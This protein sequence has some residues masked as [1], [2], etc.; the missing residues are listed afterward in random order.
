VVQ[1][2]AT[3]PPQVVP[4]QLSAEVQASPSLQVLPAQSES[5]Q[6]VFPS[7]S[8]SDRSLHVASV[9]TDPHPHTPAVQNSPL[10]PQLVPLVRLGW[11]HAPAPSQRSEVQ[12][13]LSSG[14]GVT[15]DWKRSAG[16]AELAPVHV[17]ARSHGPL[18]GRQVTVLAWKPSVGQAGLAP[19]QASALS[20]AVTAARHTVPPALR[21]CAQVPAPSQASLVQGWVS[22]AQGAP[23]AL[24]G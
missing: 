6:S 16:Q 18:A 24:G 2:F 12:R 21:G 8:L 4:L 9:E 10:A 15:L 17:S 20:H 14:Q 13:L 23:R 19:S 5:E 7:Q 11:M 22:S 1:T 3:P